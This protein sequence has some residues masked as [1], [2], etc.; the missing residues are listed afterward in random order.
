MNK[1]FSRASID[2]NFK[3]Y[4]YMNDKYSCFEKHN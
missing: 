4:H 3:N 1:K 2:T